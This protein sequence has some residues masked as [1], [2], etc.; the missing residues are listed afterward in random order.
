MN[1][2]SNIEERINALES[3]QKTLIHQ[4]KILLFV[5]TV[6]GLFFQFQSCKVN[7]KIANLNKQIEASAK[8]LAEIEKAAKAAAQIADRA[9]IKAG[10]LQE[11]VGASQCASSQAAQHSQEAQHSLT[12]IKETVVRIEASSMNAEASSKKAMDLTEATQ[13]LLTKVQE[14][15]GTASN[16]AQRAEAIAFESDKKF[17]QLDTT[18]DDMITRLTAL[19]ATRQETRTQQPQDEEP[20]VILVNISA[21]RS[22]VTLRE[23]STSLRRVNLTSMDYE[24]T[25]YVP[26]GYSAV[27]KCT[28]MDSTIFISSEL[29]GRVTVNDIGMRNRIVELK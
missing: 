23:G 7:D 29:K 5:A 1:Q 10:D 18:I 22:K 3:W 13:A 20:K 21:M 27:V 4:G 17:R 8:E 25:V 9:I 11:A 28:A 24:G 14:A 15:V 6:A 16:A 12:E 26:K 19:A 2:P